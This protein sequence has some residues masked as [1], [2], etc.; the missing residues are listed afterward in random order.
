M[1]KVRDALP[2]NTLYFDNNINIIKM[3]CVGANA[4]GR[5]SLIPRAN[6]KELFFAS[7]F[8]CDI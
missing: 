1:L 4:G 5:T 6:L 8:Y 7:P 2:L 3:N